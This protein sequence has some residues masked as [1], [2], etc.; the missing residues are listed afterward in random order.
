[1]KSLEYNNATW[2]D[3]TWKLCF[4]STKPPA[5]SP[6]S[7]ERMCQQCSDGSCL[8]K[9]QQASLAWVILV[10]HRY[11]NQTPNTSAWCLSKNASSVARIMCGS[12]SKNAVLKSWQFSK[13]DLNESNRQNSIERWS[14]IS[15]CSER[16]GVFRG[17]CNWLCADGQHIICIGITGKQKLSKDRTD[18]P[19]HRWLIDMTNCNFQRNRDSDSW[20]FHI[21]RAILLRIGHDM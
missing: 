19:F 10:K 21:Y 14:I 13:K 8:V 7:L 5:S 4:G 2:F 18:R 6:L 11:S 3:S 15:H 9:Q 20:S 16:Y 12:Y 17:S 1:M